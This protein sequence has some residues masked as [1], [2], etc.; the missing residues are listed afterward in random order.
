[1]GPAVFVAPATPVGTAR[2]RQARTRRCA[3]RVARTVT[4][5]ADRALWRPTTGRGTGHHPPRS[6]A[7][8]RSGPRMIGGRIV[9]ETVLVGFAL[10]R[11]VYVLAA[12][13]LACPGCAAPLRCAADYVPPRDESSRCGPRPPPAPTPETRCW[14]PARGGTPPLADAVEAMGQ[15]A[16]AHARWFV[17]SLPA[18]HLICWFTPGLL[19]APVPASVQRR[20]G[21][22][23]GRRQRAHGPPTPCTP[24]RRQA[25]QR[26]R[27][28]HC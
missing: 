21:Q 7:A 6:R 16:P 4:G 26:P 28:A 5:R 23:C 12:G 17:A 8:H 18:W 13:K 20:T 1:V 27:S 2:R 15:L 9:D 22:D 24:R 3:A 14:V 11:S 10:G 19:L 25:H